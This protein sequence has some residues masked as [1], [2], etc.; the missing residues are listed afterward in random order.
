[1]LDPTI[2]PMPDN[3]IEAQKNYA[4]IVEKIRKAANHHDITGQQAII[5]MAMGTDKLTSG[6]V[7]AKGYAGTNIS[8]NLKK[9][10]KLGLIK[11]GVPSG[12]RRRIMNW[13]TPDGLNLCVRLRRELAVKTEIAC[14]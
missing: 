9:L 12:D 7:G 8:Y 11:T 5:V 14:V 3:I 6:Q 4:R 2:P 13:L 1:M 10:R